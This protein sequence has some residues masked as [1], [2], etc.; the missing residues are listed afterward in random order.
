[1]AVSPSTQLPKLTNISKSS[2]MAVKCIK[3]QHKLHHM[4]PTHLAI[5]SRYWDSV[6]ASHT[7]EI[8]YAANAANGKM[9]EVQDYPFLYMKF[10]RQAKAN[11]AQQLSRILCSRKMCHFLATSLEYDEK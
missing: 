1:M 10:T 5:V 8:E 6:S 2:I 3:C 9:P 7:T 4:K 11:F